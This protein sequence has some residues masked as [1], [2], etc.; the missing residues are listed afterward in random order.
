[1]SKKGI[2]IEELLELI[3]DPRVK[4]VLT[5]SLTPIIDN[6]F[7]RFVAEFTDKIEGMV[8][9]ITNNILE[10]FCEAQTK[11]MSSLEVENANLCAKLDDAQTTMRLNNLV[12]HGLTEPSTTANSSTQ[13]S[14]SDPLDLCE[15]QLHVQITEADISFAYRIPGHVKDSPRPLIVGFT[16]KR[17]R[18]TVLA[19]RKSLKEYSGNP[20]V[21]INDHLTHLNSQIYS[22]TRKFVKAQKIHSTWT[23]GGKVFLRRSDSSYEKPTRIDSLVALDEFVDNLAN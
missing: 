14:V 9:R 17:I 6:M 22:R 3:Q 13:T 5:T 19:S 10:K 7:D 18:D 20:K 2:K 4:E 1:M 21:Y 16:R 8:E 15:N 11:K 12:I 23:N